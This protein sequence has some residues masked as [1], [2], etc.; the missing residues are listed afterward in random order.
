MASLSKIKVGTTEYDLKATYDSNG[1][2]IVDTYVLKKGDTMTGTLNVPT[3]NNYNT[4]T[5]V[6]IA[7]GT[8]ADSYF[9][10]KKFRGQG[11]AGTYNHAIDFG[12]SGH[13]QVDF[14][15]YGGIWNFWMNNQSTAVTDKATKLALTI[16]L[17]S[18]SNKSYTYTWPNKTGTFALTSDIKD[19]TYSID[20]G[21]G[22]TITLA[23]SDGTSLTKTINDVAHASSA[24][25]A[26]SLTNAPSLLTSG[27]TVAVKAGGKTSSYITVPYATKAANDGNGND[28]ASTYL[29]LSGGTVTGDFAVS[30][31]D[32]FEYSGIQE[33]S[34]DKARPV[35]FAWANGDG[36]KNG[37]PAYDSSFT[38]NPSTDVLAVGGVA[39]GKDR[40][41]TDGKSGIDLNNSDM[42]RVNAIYTDDLAQMTSEGIRFSRSSAYSAS[43]SYDT[44]VAAGGTLYFK[45]NDPLEGTALSDCYQVYHTGNLFAATSS[46]VGLMSASDKSKVDSCG[47]IWRQW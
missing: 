38:Y 28:I 25:S 23:G 30:K 33:A 40:F 32:G 4:S 21:A 42:V 41:F 3:I 29:P 10:S 6:S 17:N 5:A 24:D 45:P 47:V 15:E 35:W 43:A 26:T 36:I 19:T 20:T 16:G 2:Q 14:Y 27:N 34:T 39:A 7:T 1:N 31:A 13:N 37:R 46:S 12:Y 9:Q 44:I 22:N 11:N 18:L 8:H